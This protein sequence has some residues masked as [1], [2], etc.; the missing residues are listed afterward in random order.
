MRPLITLTT[1]F[2]PSSP[3]VAQ[4]KGVILS[5]CREVDLVDITHAIG[6]QNVREGAVVLADATPRFP[7]GAIH[8]A[9]VDPG[10]GTARR[11]VYAEIGVQRYLAPD[12]GLL[13]FLASREPPRQIVVLENAQFWLPQPSRTFHG[14]DILSPVAAHL[15]GGLDPVELGPPLDQIEMLPWPRPVKSGETISGEVLY[16]DSFGNL[17]TNLGLDDLAA[18]G[19]S[20]TVVECRGRSI[21]SV[22][23]TYGAAAE[24]EL[25]ALFD[26]QGRLEIAIAGASA[27]RSLGVRAGEPV[28]VR[29]KTPDTSQNSED[30]REI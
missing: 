12:N 3:Y 16:V 1:D 23:P 28:I 8:V 30:W 15:A 10:V 2:G 25:I 13:S 14:R 5:L 22:V 18:L 7:A 24:G 11:L 19:T 17:I 6:P 29:L 20:A 9:V 26:S 21:E 4:M 27:A